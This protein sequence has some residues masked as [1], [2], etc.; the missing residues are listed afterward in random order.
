MYPD[1]IR[2]YKEKLLLEIFLIRNASKILDEFRETQYFNVVKAW[3]ANK[4]IS[5]SIT[6]T[7]KSIRMDWLPHEIDEVRIIKIND[8]YYVI[9]L[10]FKNKFPIELPKDIMFVVNDFRYTYKRDNKNVFIL[11]SL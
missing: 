1:L 3:F 5:K 11:R 9:T 8:V 2:A 7:Q 10:D 6:D 4:T